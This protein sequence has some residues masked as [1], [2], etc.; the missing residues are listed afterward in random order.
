MRNQQRWVSVSRDADI[1][2]CGNR[3][4]GFRG[5][6]YPPASLARRTQMRSGISLR[7]ETA[8]AIAAGPVL[9]RAAMG[10]GL[11]LQAAVQF[12]LDVA[13][14]QGRDGLTHEQLL[15]C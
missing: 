3:Y 5:E 11:R 1:R 8:T 13:D 4:Q 12:D 9:H 15:S 14:D 6:G 7:M 2:C 10:G